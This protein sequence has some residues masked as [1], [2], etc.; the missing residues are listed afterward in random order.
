[1]FRGVAMLL[2]VAG[3]LGSLPL[4][5]VPSSADDVSYTLYGSA[6]SGWGFS[7]TSL[8]NPGPTLT[9]YRSDVVTLDLFAS[10]TEPHNWFIDVN[11][12]TKLDAGEP[13]SPDFNVPASENVTWNFTANLVGRYWYRCRY[14]PATM[15]GIID[16]L[17]ARPRS[18][19]LYGSAAGGW[20]LTRTN[21]TDPGPTLTVGQG[22]NVT[23]NLSA[24][25]GEPHNWFI[26]YNNNSRIDPGEPSS[27][28]FNVPE[29]TNLTWNFTATRAG[30]YTY[31][32]LY[33]P[34]TMKGLI[35]IQGTEEPPDGGT[36]QV[37]LVSGIMLATVVFVLLFAVGYHVRAVRAHRRPK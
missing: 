37:G 31:R 8:T 2:L 35:V 13:G 23:L 20:G 22:A 28:D 29:T 19:T 1:M 34:G 16:I 18:Y 32:C 6:A 15:T 17:S 11:N 25:D 4:P 30:V 33:H 21:L 12:N 10:D 14:H 26:D 3:I 27:P 9:V 7:D 36:V 5:P 24:T